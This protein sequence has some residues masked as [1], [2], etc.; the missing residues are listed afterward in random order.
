M[1]NRSDGSVVVKTSASTGVTIAA[2]AKA[3][4]AYDTSISDFVEVAPTGTGGT[5]TSV[6]VSGGSTGLTTSGGPITSSGTI[7]I[8][9]TL[10]VA[11]GGTGSTSAS[12]A[13]TALGLGDLAI[14]DTVSSGEIDNAA[15][16]PAKLSGGQSGSAPAYAVRAWLRYNAVTATTNGSG[17]VSSVT[18]AASGGYLMNFSTAMSDTNYA[19]T[20]LAV[21]TNQYKG[22]IGAP[23]DDGT[24]TS[25]TSRV[26]IT[27]VADST[28]A[29]LVP[30]RLSIMVIR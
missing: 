3:T 25:T 15:I 16:T 28:L 7:T 5:V 2:G 26:F 19:V 24:N 22:I 20:G 8:A 29:A 30:D 13:R 1:I 6:A 9:G 4:V 21:R 18:V 27:V 23:D 17:N 10:A 11:N 12:G 14:L